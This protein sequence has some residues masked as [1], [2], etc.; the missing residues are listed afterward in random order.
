MDALTLAIK[1]RLSGKNGPFT[2][3]VPALTMAQR[4][5]GALYGPSGSGKT[6]LLRIIA[7]LETPDEGRIVVNGKVWFDSTDRINLPPQR[8]SVGFVFQDYALFPAMTVEQNIMYGMRGRKD[9][10]RLSGLLESLE[11]GSLRH[12]RPSMLSGGQRQRVALARAL[13]GSPEL[14]LL[15]EPL[16]ALDPALRT[17]AEDLLLK[18]RAFFPVATVLVSHDP[19][20][21]FRL[22]E[23]VHCLQDGTIIRSGSPDAVFGSGPGS[24]NLTGRILSIVHQ[25]VLDIITV[26]V[27]TGVSRLA[28]PH[29]DHGHLATGDLIAI[30]TRALDPAVAK[31]P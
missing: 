20:E 16:A 11:I 24:L 6:T 23:R 5:H 13:A 17:S 10:K 25:G 22:A 15:D 30:S 4:G 3:E 12:H 19:G 29:S 8:R 21:I 28:L 9:R 1:K 2:L 26:S 14:L 7:G 31:L 18:M 27:G